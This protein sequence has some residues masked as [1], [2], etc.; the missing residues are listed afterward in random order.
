M[1]QFPLT[2]LDMLGLVEADAAARPLLLMTADDFHS[3]LETADD[4]TRDWADASGF[5]AASGRTLLLPGAGGAA[6]GILDRDASLWDASRLAASLPAACWKMAGDAA[7]VPDPG[8]V[9]LGW[10]LAQYRFTAY[11]AETSGEI[12][13]LVIPESLSSAGRDRL[14]GLATGVAFCRDLVNAPANHM[15]P[16]GLEDAARHLAARFDATIEV[17]EGAALADGFPAIDTVGRAAEVGP[18]LIDM[19][20]GDSG[21]KITLVGKGITFDSGGLDLK[22]S[23]AMEIMKKDMGGAATVLGLAAALMTAGVA[24]R[25]R[26][27]VPAAENAVSAKSMRPLDVIDT[28]AGIPVEVGNT[29]AEGRLVLADA[30]SLA[31]EEDPDFMIDFATLTGAA[32]V[33]LGTELPALFANRDDTAAAIIDAS[34]QAGDPLWRLP[35]FDDYERHLDAGNVALSSTGASGYG[36]A[37]TAALFLRR[38]AGRDSNWA[39][40]DVMAWN[41]GSRPGR[42][43]GGEAMGLRALFTYI[44]GLAGG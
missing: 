38:F 43:K 27:L 13:R 20:W 6:L 42:P 23:K 19:R 40:V 28:R 26:V 10:A 29:D 12:R 37:I 8:T 30:I 9:C 3:W 33:A 5:T 34:V 41:L 44:E 16:A 7:D 25:L 21:P 17:T 22:P 2:D 36:G 14:A 11:R 39:H 35:L 32:R 31:C 24:I 18:R 15:T 4:A 1:M